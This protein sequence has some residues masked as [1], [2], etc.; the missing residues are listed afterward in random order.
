MAKKTIYIALAVGIVAGGIAVASV[1]SWVRPALAQVGVNVTARP[2]S[3]ISAE[4]MGTLR[5]LN[6]SF[7][8]LAEYV[9]PSVVN[10]R[11]EGQGGTD[12]LGRR[13]GEVGGV[14]TGVI[15]RSDGWIV[16]NDHVVNGFDKVTVT[17][18]DGREFKGQVRAVSESDIAVVKIDATDLT[19]ANFADSSKVKPGEFTM[20]V[21]LPAGA[22]LQQGHIQLYVAQAGLGVPFEDAIPDLKDALAAIIDGLLPPGRRVIHLLCHWLLELHA[23][24][25]QL[26]ERR[27]FRLK[28]DSRRHACR[29]GTRLEGGRTDPVDRR[30]KHQHCR[31]D[32]NDRDGLADALSA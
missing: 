10:I 25:K 31:N 20:A 9:S 26:D 1:N 11:S 16:T 19:A 15:F 21:S 8:A 18:S 4:D 24:G 30:E 28:D 7:A 2:I 27:H 23:L 14:G 29:D 12:V 22:C 6:Q 32:R 17:L 5:G 13:M 3:S